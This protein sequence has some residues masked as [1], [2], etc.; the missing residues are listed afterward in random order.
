MIIFRFIHIAST[1][2]YALEGFVRGKRNNQANMMDYVAKKQH[3][4]VSC[5]HEIVKK[6]S[7]S[8][9]IP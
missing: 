5:R 3:I 7:L 2:K 6:L 9:Y 1:I 8:V 4:S